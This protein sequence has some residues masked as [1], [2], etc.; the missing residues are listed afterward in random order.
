MQKSIIIFEFICTIYIL[1]CFN[2]ALASPEAQVIRNLSSMP[3]TFTENRGQWDERVLFRADA[4][5][6]TMWFMQDGACYQFTRRIE[7]S[8]SEK[9]L[10]YKNYDPIFH[11][12]D[13]LET[14]MIKA[15]F[16]G[17][18]PDPAICGEDMLGYKCNYFIGNNPEKW[19]TNVPNY[20]AIVFQDIY[21][22]IDLKYYGNNK[23]MEYDFIVSPGADPSQICIRYEGAD[24][25]SVNENGELVIDTD[26]GSVVECKPLVYQIRG[27]KSVPTDCAYSLIDENRLGFELVN[28]YD[29]EYALIIDPVLSYSTY[30]GGSDEEISE[31]ITIDDSDN[32][33]ITGE[34]YSTD[35]PTEGG[36]QSNQPGWDVFIAKFNSL[37]SNFIYCTYLGG[38][39]GDWGSSIFIDDSG[40][41][42]IGGYTNSSDFPTEGP[43]QTAQGNM[44]AF[45]T[46]LNSEGNG[47]VFSTYLGGS[48]SD[49]GTGIS[50][51]NTNHAYIVGFTESSDYPTK[52][53][54]QSDQSGR[55]VFI[56]KLG[57]EGDT[58]VYSTYLGGGGIDNGTA[59]AVDDFGN[60]YI[61]GSTFS[62]DFPT[63][64][65]YQTY[66][67]GSDCDA[68]VTKLYSSGDSLV[69]SSYLGGANDVDEGHAITVDTYGNAYITGRTWSSDFPVEGEYQIY[70]GNESSDAF[71]TKFNSDGSDLVYST[72]LGGFDADR[73]IGISIDAEGN[74][75]VTGTT[76]SSDFPT[77][78]E[79]QTYQGDYDAFVT[80]FNS[81]GNAL[82]F[83]TYLG[84]DDEDTGHSIAVDISGNAYITGFT[85][86]TD[87]P[88]EN[89]YQTDQGD[90]DVFVTKIYLGPTVDSLFPSQNTLNIPANTDITVM[91]DTDMNPATIN[92]TTFV[93]HASQTGLHS[94]IISYDAPSRTATFDPDGDF[95]VGEIV[96]ATLSGYIESDFGVPMGASYTWQ[97]TVAV[98]GGSGEFVTASTHGV[99]GKPFS[100]FTADL[101]ADGA[102]DIITA[103]S[104]ADSVSVFLNSGDGN[105]SGYISYP[106]GIFPHSGLRG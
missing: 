92:D 91:F 7:K 69:Y 81:A 74:A 101:N 35:F 67:G 28:G 77:E 41:A 50:L 21:P 43:Y 46:K 40:N 104:G 8:R 38:D 44:D 79:F 16:V 39:G 82:V 15:S 100:L 80:K 103:D 68:F 98:S 64:E 31:S 49:H 12:P 3:L 72:F 13:S 14:I 94:G 10:D 48:G 27:G 60:A 96:T 42:Y 78:A 55:D 54:Y 76:N 29:P 24:S 90:R 86:S 93:V 56:T 5:R 17:A 89:E 6:A 97:F 105:F 70:Q 88:T 30:L 37:G 11:K 20:K 71:V 9:S 63:E 57:I 65:A 61:T 45:V 32:I 19:Q 25:V 53:E 73:G 18:N 36:Y 47:L 102:M 1:G 23:Q 83:S 59:I 34:T 66:P 4:G 58:L 85:S 99:S 87:F 22:G 84:G 33:Y 51:D 2:L 95:A 52:N 75:Y 106:T 26:W 62:T